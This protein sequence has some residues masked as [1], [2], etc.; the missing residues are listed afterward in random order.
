MAIDMFLDLGG[1]VKGESSDKTYAGKIDINSYHWGLSQSGTFHL[2]TGGGAGKVSVKDVQI[3]KLVDSATPV[4]M[5]YAAQG[6]HFD[7]GKIIVRKAGGESPVEYVVMEMSQVMISSVDHM[8]QQGDDR[9][10]EV[11]T[12]NFAKVKFTYTPQNKDGSKGA[13]IDF[14]W[15]IAQ[16]TAA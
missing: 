13:A 4:L 14:K 6:K 1:S 3:E 10:R 11:V 8:G 16:N 5:N 12:L 2:G 9:L 7:T 15:D